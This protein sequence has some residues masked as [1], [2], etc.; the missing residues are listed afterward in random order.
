MLKQEKTESV[1]L[2]TTSKDKNKKMTKDK[3]AA[4]GPAQ[5]K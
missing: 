5:K 3:K 4:S 2:A 1:H